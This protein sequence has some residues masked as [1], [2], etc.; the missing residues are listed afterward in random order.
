MKI[1][2]HLRRITL[3]FTFSNECECGLLFKQKI[4]QFIEP[5][6]VALILL[7]YGFIYDNK[8]VSNEYI[9]RYEHTQLINLRSQRFDSFIWW[10]DSNMMLEHDISYYTYVHCTV[11]AKVFL[12]VARMI[13]TNPIIWQITQVRNNPRS[14]SEATLSQSHTLY[15]L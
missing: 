2:Q 8:H 13:S 9:Y 3:G 10:S 7:W 6:P 11:F 14:P 15:S 5:K 12:R 4:R 1:I